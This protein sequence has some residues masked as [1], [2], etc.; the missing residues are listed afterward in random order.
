MQLVLSDYRHSQHF[1]G[2]FSRQSA[3]FYLSPFVTGYRPATAG[4]PA[5]PSRFRIFSPPPRRRA[6]SHEAAA[7]CAYCRVGGSCLARRLR[8]KNFSADRQKARHALKPILISL[9]KYMHK[10]SNDA[11]Y[12][13]C[14][15]FIFQAARLCAIRGRRRCYDTIRRCHFVRFLNR[16]ISTIYLCLGNS[17]QTRTTMRYRQS[18]R[19]RELI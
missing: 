5:P 8:L 16:I 17:G 6:S 19:T 13:S 7:C 4:L 14:F 9:L 2:T 12:I 10:H 3:Y 15:R 18:R 1:A 11:S